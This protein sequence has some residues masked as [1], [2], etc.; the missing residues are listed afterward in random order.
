MRADSQLP[1]SR[2]LPIEADTILVRF[3]PG[4]ARVRNLLRASAADLVWPLPPGL[5]S[6]SLPP[7]YLGQT[8]DAR[9]TRRLLLVMRTDLPPT[10]RLGTR[11]ALAHGLNRGE[12]IGEL[13][14]AGR[15]LND[16][17]P[18]GGPYEFPALDGARCASG[19]RRRSSGARSTSR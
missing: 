8:Q 1:W 19:W 9:P 6:E 15:E 5:L 7:G 14:F 17:L 18:G 4:A 11:H 16:W 2:A 13:G 12:L 10:T 3:T